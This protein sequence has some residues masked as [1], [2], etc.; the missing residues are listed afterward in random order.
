MCENGLFRTF[1]GR[2]HGRIG[3]SYGRICGKSAL[4]SISRANAAGKTAVWG[5]ILAAFAAGQAWK[6]DFPQ[7][8][9]HYCRKTP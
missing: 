9:Q 2:F 7:M 1:F 4:Q 8:R 5:E 3:D 6:A